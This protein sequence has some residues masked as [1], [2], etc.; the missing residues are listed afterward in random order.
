MNKAIM[1]QPFRI[2]LAGLGTVGAGVV[3][4]VQKNGDLLARRAGRPIEIVSV[5]ARDKNKDRGVDL[6]SYSWMDN[7]VQMADAN[8]IDAVVEMIGGSDGPALALTQTALGRGLHVVTAN[9]AMLAHHGYELAK[10]AEDNKVCLAYEAAV[11]G[12]IPIIKSMR[13]GYAANEIQAV[14]GILNGTCNYILTEMRE[15]GRDFTDVLKDAQDKGYAEAD[16]SFDIDG[17]DAGHKLC[18]L[19]AIA[20][21]T[22]PDFASLKMTGIRQINKTDIA[23][24]NELGYRI[25]LL[26]TARRVNG[27]IMQVLEPCLVPKDSPLGTVEGVYN[28]VMVEGDFVKTGLSEGRGA[29]EGPT[30]SAIVADIIDLARGL[31][32]PT[33]GV[34][35]NDLVKPEWADL[36]ETIN[37]YY[38]RLTVL[39]QAGVIAG[40]SG[41]LRDHN[42]SIEGFIQRGRD[43]GQPV[44]VVMTTHEVKHGDVLAACAKMEKLDFCIEKPCLMRVEHIG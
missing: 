3:K 22:R 30:A 12:G 25:K 36:N 5:S 9:K 42:I 15:T 20:F 27:K 39:D 4:I 33:F 44:P 17:V 35:A 37:S 24:A 21:G 1:A 29:G 43:P 11:A 28:A 34:P 38:I 41:I 10:M 26:G 7:A 13:E 2:A 16:P 8:D 40:V 23:F 31:R 32:V 14:Y 6:S 19:S 18:L